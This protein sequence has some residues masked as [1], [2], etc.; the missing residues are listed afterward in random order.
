MRHMSWIRWRRGLY[1]PAILALFAIAVIAFPKVTHTEASILPS[2]FDPYLHRT[3]G[4]L[5]DPI[6]LVFL[7]ATPN[8]VAAA[9]HRVLG[10]PIVAGS[11]MIFVDQGVRHPTAWQLGLPETR[12]SR[13]HMRIEALAPDAKQTYVL[14]AVHHDQGAACGHVGGDFAR[15][16]DLV[17]RAFAAAD[18][19]VTDRIRGNTL[20]ARQCDGSF[21]RGDGR[22]A[23]IDLSHGSARQPV[24]VPAHTTAPARV[25]PESA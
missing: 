21:T 19:R 23:Y 5:A 25:A 7:H 17:A 18:Y 2:Q 6:N 12:G 24:S 16:R 10:W 11:P 4:T 14:A 13:L 22:I 20:S 3:S 9:V 15:E 8:S 1:L